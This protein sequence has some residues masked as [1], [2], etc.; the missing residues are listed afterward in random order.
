MN[1]HAQTSTESAKASGR[2]GRWLIALGVL[3]AGVAYAAFRRSSSTPDPWSTATPYSPPTPPVR[4]EPESPL[5][6]PT[7]ADE[8]AT[9]ESRGELG[10]SEVPA[11]ATHA[12]HSTEDTED[13]TADAEDSTADGPADEDEIEAV[14]NAEAVL[15]QGIEEHE[16]GVPTH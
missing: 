2:T 3:A 7:L 15:A 8:V 11:V 5:E 10:V 14:A 9:D 6:D 4:P 13:S 12:E 1:D 16:G